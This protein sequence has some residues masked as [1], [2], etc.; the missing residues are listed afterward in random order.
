MS[1][2]DLL[3][4]MSTL[5]DPQHGCPWD[6]EQNFRSI[7]AHTIEEAYEVI[8]AIERNDLDDLREELGDLLFQVVFHSQLA[9]ELQAFDFQDVVTGI[10]T[11]LQ[12]RHPHVFATERF[13][14]AAQQTLAWEEIKRRE[15]AARAMRAGR[16]TMEQ[17]QGAAAPSMLADVPLALPALTRA[18]KLGR[19]ASQA[20]FRWPDIAGALDKLDEEITEMH[21]ELRRG[22][23][24][25]RIAAEIGDVLFCLVN[26][27]GYLQLDAE[28]CLRGTNS[29]FERRFRHVERRLGERGSDPLRA[30]LEEMDALWEEAKQLGQ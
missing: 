5:R 25:D 9:Q 6:L 12:R 16:N 26:L 3:N 22:A 14:T 29:K 11:K 7:A 24:R 21:A 15:R 19:R 28:A 27:C 20:G 8:D 10:C 2:E 30:S 18:A 13:D 23:D 1:I 17:G 4:I